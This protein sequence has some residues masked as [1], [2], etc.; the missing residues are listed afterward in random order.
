MI[1][2]T[3]KITILASLLVATMVNAQEF[4]TCV[5]KQNWWKSTIQMSVP[6]SSTELNSLIKEMR[7]QK[8]LLQSMLSAIRNLKSS[9][10]DC[11]RACLIVNLDTSYYSA[12]QVKDLIK[13]HY[14]EKCKKIC[15]Y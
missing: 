3:S 9:S 7:E 12:Y 2:K 14:N 1:K 13:E 11:Y 5:P 10:Y 4:Y 15:S 6:N 8:I